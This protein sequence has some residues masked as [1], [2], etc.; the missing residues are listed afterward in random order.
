MLVEKPFT[1]NAAEA[2]EVADLAA[3]RG[4]ARARGDVDEV[5]AAHGAHPRDHRRGR[6]RRGAHAH[7]R[8]HAEA[9]RRPRATA[10]TRSSSAAAP[11]STSASTRSRSRGTC[12][13]RRRPIQ[14]SA[15][16]K[17]TGADAQVATIFGYEGGRMASI[18]LGERHEG[19]EHRRRA[20]HARRASRSTRSGT[21]RRRSG[22]VAADGTVIEEYSSE[23]NG[24]GM[25]FQ[26]AAV[27]RLVAEGR[28]D[29]GDAPLDRRDRRDH[30]HARRDP[31]ADRPALPGRVT[32]ARLAESGS[33]TT[34]YNARV[35]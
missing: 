15:T 13:V 4:P 22:V 35:H 20:R 1:L 27:E 32:A 14:A 26:A 34:A 29:G 8:P 10:S 21:R 7:R 28:L 5:P 18:A 17:A 12:S 19:S 30:G 25:H 23:V 6:A 33:G 11:C 31:R 2:R 3:D 24:R 16:F 9:L